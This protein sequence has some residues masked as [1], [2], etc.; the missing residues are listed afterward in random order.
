[1]PKEGFPLRIDDSLL[2]WLRE[3]A[4]KVNRSVNNFIETVLIDYKKRTEDERG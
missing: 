2:D 3:E 1:M 4:Q